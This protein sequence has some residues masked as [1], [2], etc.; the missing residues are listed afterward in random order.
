MFSH[1]CL[2]VG[3]VCQSPNMRIS[4]SSPT[5]PQRCKMQH[6]TSFNTLDSTHQFI[7]C[8]FGVLDTEKHKSKLGCIDSQPT[9]M[10][11]GV[12]RTDRLN[13][14]RPNWRLNSDKHNTM[15]IITTRHF[16]SLHRTCITYHS[17]C[18]VQCIWCW[19]CGW[20]SHESGT[21]HSHYYIC[22]KQKGRKNKSF[23]REKW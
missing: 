13:T 9:K 12:I 4:D 21:T 20:C 23:V 3:L 6:S 16:L 15:M 14:D 10:L 5:G 1:R 2:P 22:R 18:L 11:L 8:E 17:W 19:T 7:I